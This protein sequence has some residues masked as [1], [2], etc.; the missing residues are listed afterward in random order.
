MYWVLRARKT[1]TTGKQLMGGLRHVEDHVLC[2]H[3]AVSMYLFTRFTLH[4]ERLPE[5]TSDEF[6]KLAMFAGSNS[7]TNVGANQFGDYLRRAAARR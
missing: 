1:Q 4:A 2:L 3:H 6:F 5:V 7:S